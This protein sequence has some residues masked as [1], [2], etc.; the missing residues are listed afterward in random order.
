MSL[1]C[2]WR[3]EDNKEDECIGKNLDVVVHG[4]ISEN[5]SRLLLDFN[6][7]GFSIGIQSLIG[8]RE[9]L[10]QID[11]SLFPLCGHSLDLVLS[12]NA[13]VSEN[14]GSLLNQP[15]DLMRL[16]NNNTG[17]APGSTTVTLL[18]EVMMGLRTKTAA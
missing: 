16:R 17:S 6:L 7:Q 15:P 4:L 12:V 9:R 2:E 18:S 14:D 3:L 10:E 11:Q 1:T 8:L 13:E 5:T